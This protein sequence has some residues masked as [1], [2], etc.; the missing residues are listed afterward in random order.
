[1]HQSLT[2]Y[3]LALLIS[4]L[5]IVP[6]GYLIRFAGNEWWHDF[7]GSVTYEIFWVLLV[8]LFLP[9]V[10]LW[11]VAIAVL[12]TTCLIEFLQLWQNP[13]YLALK[14]TF[15]GRLVLGNTFLWADFPS[16]FVGTFVGWLWARSLQQRFM[17]ANH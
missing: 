17:K 3:R 4:I 11:K 6:A 14:A 5:I 16:Y 15:I 13:A 1:M 7:L 9:R 12:L 8:A 2:R 10:A